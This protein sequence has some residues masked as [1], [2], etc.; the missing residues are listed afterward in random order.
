MYFLKDDRDKKLLLNF[1][2]RYMPKRAPSGFM[3]MRGKR[4][5]DDDREQ[6]NKRAP[7]GFL[8]NQFSQHTLYYYTHYIQNKKFTFRNAR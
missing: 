5:F 8:G 3:G 2:L 1:P 7:S 6:L 4:L